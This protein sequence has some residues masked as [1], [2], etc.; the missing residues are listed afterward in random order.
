EIRRLDAIVSPDQVNVP[1]GTTVHLQGD[2][3]G[4]TQDPPPGGRPFVWTLL[5]RPATS[6]AVLADE[7]T[8]TPSLM[9]DAAGDYLVQLVVGRNEEA[10]APETVLISTERPAT[11]VRVIATDPD[12]SETGPDPGLFTL[13]RDGGDL[14][15]P[16]TVTFTYDLTGAAMPAID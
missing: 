13:V 12:A 14:T 8:Q 10:R 11:E 9:I 6:Q 15:R 2:V 7:T 4:V 1:I 5:K 3:F 16:L